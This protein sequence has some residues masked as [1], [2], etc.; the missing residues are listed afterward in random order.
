MVTK[1]CLLNEQGRVPKWRFDYLHGRQLIAV[2]LCFNLVESKEQLNV[3]RA[4]V[5]TPQVHCDDVSLIWTC[6]FFF[7]ITCCQQTQTGTITFLLLFCVKD[8]QIL[9]SGTFA[10][11]SRQPGF[12]RAPLFFTCGKWYVISIISNIIFSRG[13]FHL[14]KQPSRCYSL[15]Y[16]HIIT[17]KQHATVSLFY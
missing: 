13:L 7:S 9:V 5:S 12:A 6:R 11:R 3:R 2:S 10:Y 15:K 1:C 16:H 8:H 4:G 14:G 17:L